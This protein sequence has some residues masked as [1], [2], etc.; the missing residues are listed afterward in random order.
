M[1][2][3]ENIC[4]HF[5]STSQ[6]ESFDVSIVFY[7]TFGWR[8][9]EVWKFS[10]SRVVEIEKQGGET[11]I[12]WRHCEASTKVFSQRN[13]WITREW[14]LN[15]LENCLQSLWHKKREFLTDSKFR[16]L[17]ETQL[18]VKI[19]KRGNQNFSSR[20]HPGLWWCASID[21]GYQK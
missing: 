7:A 2:V 6:E 9:I 8:D 5:D 19:L 11:K 3:V 20:D 17:A 4:V 13:V 16:C 1:R 18:K 14:Y 10:V 12:S 15:A 21:D